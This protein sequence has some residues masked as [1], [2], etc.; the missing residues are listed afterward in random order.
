[1]LIISQKQ[2]L[3]MKISMLIR[4]LDFMSL[5]TYD[6]RGVFD[7]I[8]SHHSA[9]FVGSYESNADIVYNAVHIY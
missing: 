5:M 3:L 4:Y 2:S 8:A 6:L 9:L 7:Q 1:M